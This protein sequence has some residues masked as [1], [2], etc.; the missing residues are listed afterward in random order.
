MQAVVLAAGDGDRLHPR[1]AHIPKPLLTLGGRPII[2]HV[3]DG[4]HAAGVGDVAIVLGYR[5]DQIRAA[6]AV[7]PPPREMRLR[8]VTND[9]YTVG[10][11][12]SLWS[13]HNEVDGPFLL[14]M[15]DHLVDPA[16]TRAV[17]E[18]ADGRCRLAVERLRP[19]DDGRAADAT[20]ARVRDGLVV[21]L[22]KSIAEWDALDTGTFWCTPAVFDAI[23][24]E[25]RDGELSAVFATLAR[26]GAL[27]ALDVTGFRWIDIDTERDLGEAE[28]MLSTS[29]LHLPVRDGE[30]PDGR[31]A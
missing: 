25:L 6:L 23:T 2:N 19:D 5:G 4:L 7:L 16:L 1:T 24:P 12:R 20:R 26:A 29:A 10:N 28:V 13:A 17:A 30:A 31:L 9:E 8:F 27:D 21:D 15:A 11:A 3:L 22:G 14:A 18:R